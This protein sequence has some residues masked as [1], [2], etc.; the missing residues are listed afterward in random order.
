MMYCIYIQ[1]VCYV[2][3]PQGLFIDNLHWVTVFLPL[4]ILKYLL[5]VSIA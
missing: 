1:Y 4:D 2:L 5:C 3:S